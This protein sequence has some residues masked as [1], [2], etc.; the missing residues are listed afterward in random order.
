MMPF[1]AICF[2][3]MLSWCFS[4]DLSVLRY[5][6]WDESVRSF[7]DGGIRGSG[8]RPCYAGEPVSIFLTTGFFPY[9]V[10]DQTPEGRLPTQCELCGLKRRVPGCRM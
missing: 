2:L 4:C 1:P 3:C 5:D 6:S 7:R 9:Q 10:M 8:W